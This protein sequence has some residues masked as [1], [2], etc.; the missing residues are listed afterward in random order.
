MGKKTVALAMADRAFSL[1]IRRRYADEHTGRVNCVTCGANEHWSDMDCGHYISRSVW[2]VRFD[3]F[4]CMAQC[5]KCNRFEN[6]KSERFRAELVRLR[7]LSAIENLER[8]AK[9]KTQIPFSIDALT[10]ITKLY[11]SLANG[12]EIKTDKIIRDE[13]QKIQAEF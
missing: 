4:N 6:G 11:R 3:T 2:S 7:G 9:R 10:V 12:H 5:R 8:R 1:Y 13:I